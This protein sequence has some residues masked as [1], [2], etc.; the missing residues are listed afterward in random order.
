MTLPETLLG[1]HRAVVRF[2]C[3]ET[4]KLLIPS[5]SSKKIKIFD[6]SVYGL[7]KKTKNFL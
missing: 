2:G 1:T 6:F 4:L 5:P 3:C 7:K